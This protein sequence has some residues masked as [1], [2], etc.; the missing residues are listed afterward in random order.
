MNDEELVPVLRVKDANKALAWYQ[1]MGFVAT[2]VH[3][4]ESHL[5]AYMFLERG[6]VHLHLSEH[7]GDAPRKGLVYFYLA[8][9]DEIAAE[10]AAPIEQAPW[11]RELSLED[12]DGN[13]VRCGE[14]QKS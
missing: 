12:P 11:G 9:M 3:R 5:P 6:T 8:N 4:F 2:G 1:R 7:K 14:I 13:R 10:Y